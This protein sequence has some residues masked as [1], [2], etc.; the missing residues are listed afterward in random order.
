MLKLKTLIEAGNLITNN[1]Y[2][3]QR[4]YSKE[5]GEVTIKYVI[6]KG[7]SKIIVV[8]IIGDYSM[9][10]EL[11]DIVDKK[12]LESFVRELQNEIN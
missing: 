11:I 3:L 7:S 2:S 12:A 1:N 4:T 9:F 10:E 6:Q 8:K 5:D